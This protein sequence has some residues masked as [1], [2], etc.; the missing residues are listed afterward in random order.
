MS[1]KETLLWA[2]QIL[3]M[4]GRVLEVGSLNVNGT[5]RKILPIT[6]GIDIREG[7]D[8]DEVL[9]ACDLLERFGA[10]SWDH[11]VTASCFEHVERW[12]VALYNTWGVLKKGG[13]FLFEVPTLG[14]HF[15][16]HPHDY[17]RW[18]IPLL[19]QTFKDQEIIS[20]AKTWEKGVGCICRKVTELNYVQPH[21]L[22]LKKKKK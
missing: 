19:E 14:K 5:L 20:I 17:W 4:D 10:G 16:A 22:D 8:V 13:K 3:P 21:A 15:H 18:D 9:D 12:D 7:R 1:N 6:H 11:V 2:K